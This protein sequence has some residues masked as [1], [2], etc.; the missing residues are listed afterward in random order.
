MRITN[1]NVKYS[2]SV[3]RGTQNASDFKAIQVKII[4]PLYFNV[5]IRQTLKID[6]AKKKS[7]IFFESDAKKG[8]GKQEI[9]TLLSQTS[10]TASV[11]ARD[12]TY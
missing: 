11:T 3:G 7:E 10:F 8:G 4:G 5:Y 6:L 12:T 2:R 9:D 1:T